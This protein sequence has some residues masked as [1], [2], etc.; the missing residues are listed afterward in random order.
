MIEIK[1]LRWFKRQYLDVKLGFMYEERK[2]AYQYNDTDEVELWNDIIND[3]R[4][5]LGYKE[6][7]FK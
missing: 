7:N 2:I 3:T 1:I 5:Q 6:D 4:K